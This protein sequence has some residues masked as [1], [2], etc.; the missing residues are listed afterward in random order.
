MRAVGLVLFLAGCISMHGAVGASA[1]GAGK[2][3]VVSGGGGVGLWYAYRQKLVIDGT[4]M[5]RKGP[6]EDSDGM[7]ALGLH[8]T[9]KSHG[10]RPGYWGSFQ[11]GF[12][13]DDDGS[14]TQDH[15]LSAIIAGAGVAWTA[16]SAPRT[17]FGSGA[18][19]S[20]RVGVVYEH[21]DQSDLGSGDFLGIALHGD[22]GYN[23]VEVIVDTKN[24][25]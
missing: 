3:D 19:A 11:Y 8:V 9:S 16:L 24:H 20:I 7:L 15:S 5:L 6:L 22:V 21:E 1:P 12:A 18:F 25:K 14:G 17:H 13:S 10:W 23:L 4:A 2:S